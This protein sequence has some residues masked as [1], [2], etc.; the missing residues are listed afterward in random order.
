MSYIYSMFFNFPEHDM[1]S[2]E[3]ATFSYLV[4]DAN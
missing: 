1:N 2:V 4:G 3:M